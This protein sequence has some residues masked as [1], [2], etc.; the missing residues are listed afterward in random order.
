MCLGVARRMHS[1][2][3]HASHS[4]FKLSILAYDLIRALDP[5]TD[6]EDPPL[7][8]G[9]VSVLFYSFFFLGI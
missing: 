6:K 1:G 7:R 9:L 3:G 5:Q 4:M 2:T 8:A